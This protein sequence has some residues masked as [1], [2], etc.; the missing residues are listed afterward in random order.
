MPRTPSGSRNWPTL[1]IDMRYRLMMMALSLVVLAGCAKESPGARK[2]VY[3]ILDGIPADVVERLYLPAMEEIA[4]R[5][6]YVRSY[7]GGGVGRYDQTPTISAVGYTDLLTATWVNK[8][9]VPGN[10]NLSPNYNYWTIFRIAKEQGRDV[11]T[12]LFS[13]WVDNRTVLI[14]EGKPETGGL[15]IDYVSD[16][17][18]L[19]KESFPDREDDLRI[20]DIDEYV[21]HE[22]AKCIRDKAPDLSWVYLWYTDDAGHLF[23]DGEYFD[24]YVR[25]ADRQVARIWEAV[26]YR[27]ENFGEEWMVI[28][29][30][31]HGRTWDGHGHGGQS[32]RERT[33]WLASNV[34]LNSRAMQG[35]SAIVDIAP[36]ICRF[37]G[38]DVPRDVLWEQDGTPLIGDIDIMDM[39]ATPYGDRVRLTWTCLDESAVARVWAAASNDYRAGGRDVWTE[40]GT[41]GA[42]CE[43]YE[44]NLSALPESDFYKFVLETPHGTLNRWFVR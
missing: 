11:T 8:H 43:S 32:L 44:V 27:E 12:G 30:T 15:T 33:T 42:G 38:F 36:S 20:F 19:D 23:G 29:T 22:A 4:S 14:G 41:V 37:M 7:V 18:E 28:V 39:D 5:G 40:V 1:Y 2:A 6:A 10:D 35:R 17:Y 25:L 13:S 21:S 34:P 3:I 16:G 9:N 31:D 24:E 26:K